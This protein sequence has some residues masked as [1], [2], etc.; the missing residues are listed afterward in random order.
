MKLYDSSNQ[1][2]GPGGASSVYFKHGWASCCMFVED[3]CSSINLFK[4]LSL[5][6]ANKSTR[7]RPP[8]LSGVNQVYYGRVKEH[9][10]RTSDKQP[11]M[12]TFMLRSE[13]QR[14][15]QAS[16]LT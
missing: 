16:D 15:D 6:S 10:T 14:P 1:V 12:G 7:S 13:E 9:E 3:I 5:D 11:G 8:H 4:F 2:L